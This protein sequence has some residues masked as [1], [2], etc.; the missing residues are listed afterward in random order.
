MIKKILSKIPFLI[1]MRIWYNFYGETAIH[2]LSTLFC[3]FHYRGLYKKF[4]DYSGQKRFLLEWK[5]IW[6][7]LEDNTSELDFEPHYTYHPAWAA[8]ILAKINPEKHIDI[9]SSRNFAVMVSAFIPVDYYEYRPIHLT[10]SNLTCRQADLLSLPFPDKTVKSLS[11]MHVIEH[12][13]LGRYGDGV[14]YDGDLKA[15]REI[16]RVMAPGGDLLMVLPLNKEPVISFNAHRMY[17]YQQVIEMFKDFALISFSLVK[18]K[19]FLE[20]AD[21][22]DVQGCFFACGCFWFRRNAW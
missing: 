18:G 15:V 12:I 4:A 16:S 21:E 22:S 14:D 5:K 7:C 6:L 1:W 17:T 19:D 9:S 11:C 8:R 10:L 3:Y 13:G 20:N 2:N